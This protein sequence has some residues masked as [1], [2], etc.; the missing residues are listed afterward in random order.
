MKISNKYIIWWDSIT[1][2]IQNDYT[3]EVELNTS[4]DFATSIVFY[5]SDS[6][7]EIENAI[8]NLGLIK[9]ELPDGDINAVVTVP[10]W[11]YDERPI[12]VSLTNEQ[13]ISIAGDYPELLVMIKSNGV[14][15]IK[16]DGYVQVY[17]I[18]L[19]AEHEQ[20]L[21][22]YGANIEKK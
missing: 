18:E 6:L 14:P 2:E 12:R 5:A 19:Q 17:F 16:K 21:L 4:F 8:T 9:I 15:T 20:L 13:V 7:Q 10:E 22:G 3:K 1:K 11:V